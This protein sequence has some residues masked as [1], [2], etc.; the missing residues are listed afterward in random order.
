[1][2]DKPSNKKKPAKHAGLFKKGVSGNPKGRPNKAKQAATIIKKM[3][4]ELEK[5]EVKEK[6]IDEIDPSDPEQSLKELLVFYKIRKNEA[7]T[8]DEQ[9]MFAAKEADIANKLLPYF[10][11][12]K[13]SVE[14]EENKVDEMIITFKPQEAL[15]E[16]HPMIKVLV[17]EIL[18]KKK[19]DKKNKNN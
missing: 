17:H 2:S 4:A 12:R 5:E 6:I 14:A 9:V 3:K 8:P 10:S 15:T 18:N 1:M 19:N 11:H 13:A 7:K 16:N